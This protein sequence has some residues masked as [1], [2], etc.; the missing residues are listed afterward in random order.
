MGVPRVKR[1]LL[2]VAGYPIGTTN[3]YTAMP[4]NNGNTHNKQLHRSFHARYY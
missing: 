1:W 4:Y 3:P 2:F